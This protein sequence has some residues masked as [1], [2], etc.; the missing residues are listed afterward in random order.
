MIND[1]AQHLD[2]ETDA[3]QLCFATEDHKERTL[4]F[5][6]KRPWPQPKGK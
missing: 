1:I 2:W 6:E 4:A 3:Q 5:L